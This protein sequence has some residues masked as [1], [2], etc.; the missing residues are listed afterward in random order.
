M[1]YGMK[2][3]NSSLQYMFTTLF[4]KTLTHSEIISGNGKIEHG[5]LFIIVSEIIIR[6]IALDSAHLHVRE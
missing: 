6:V 2:E 5:H 4:P 1:S 3:T